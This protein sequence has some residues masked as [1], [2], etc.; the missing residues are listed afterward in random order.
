MDGL[1]SMLIT[2]EDLSGWVIFLKIE[3]KQSLPPSFLKDI[4]A[5]DDTAFKI[6]ANH[7]KPCPNNAAT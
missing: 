5:A 3:P 4:P 1:A 6:G 7:L 2:A